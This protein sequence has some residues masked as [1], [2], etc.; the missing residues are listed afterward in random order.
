MGALIVDNQNPG[1][2]NIKRP[3]HCISPTFLFALGQFRLSKLQC[4]VQ[5]IRKFFDLD[6]LGEIAKKALGQAHFDVA[7]IG[8]GA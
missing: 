7:G 6:G 3:N 2:E 8:I 4:R 1:V 5:R